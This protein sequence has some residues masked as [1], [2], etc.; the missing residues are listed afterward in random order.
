MISDVDGKRAK[1]TYAHARLHKEVESHVQRERKCFDTAGEMWVMCGA[2]A[3][4]ESSRCGVSWAGRVDGAER[5]VRFRTLM[6]SGSRYGGEHVNDMF[7]GMHFL[8]MS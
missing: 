6:V 5:G 1:A 2:G 4:Y 3:A 8:E 7:I